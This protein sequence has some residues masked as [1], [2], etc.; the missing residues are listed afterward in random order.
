[1]G[2]DWVWV[3]AG[4][5]LG[6]MARVGVG[7]LVSQ[8]TGTTFPWGTLTV[9]LTGAF[10]IGLLLAAAEEPA[11]WEFLALG[12]LGAYTTVSAFSLQANQLIR[13]GRI[14]AASAYVVASLCGCPLV[15]LAAMTFGLEVL[16]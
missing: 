1:M 12:L 8:R 9:N 15:A 4:G 2:M 11:A 13:A 14:R 10:A 3:A 16:W 6:S 5:A 7:L